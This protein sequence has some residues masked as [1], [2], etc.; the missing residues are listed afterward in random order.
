MKRRFIFVICLVL[1][2][3]CACDQQSQAT[4]KIYSE[5][6]LYKMYTEDGKWY[7]EF[8]QP[9][10]GKVGDA[11]STNL[12]AITYPEFD[13]ATE[14]ADMLKSGIIRDD[15][16]RYLKRISKKNVVE[17]LN[18]NKICELKTPNS[19][20]CANVDWTSDVIYKFSIRG[21]EANGYVRCYDFDR[22]QYTKKFE[23]YRNFP[24][25][26]HTVTSDITVEDRNARTVY[27]YTS[28]CEMKN[29]LYKITAGESDI[30]VREIYILRYFDEEATSDTFTVSDTVPDSIEIWGSDGTHCWYGSFRDFE[31][32]PSVEWLSSFR[33][34]PIE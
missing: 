34:T 20:T 28:A 15:C 23:E 8:L 17:I 13:S 25:E 30:Y 14:F 10:D 4:Q 2:L 26:N 6:E 22:E 3:L 24:N 5:S 21:E 12:T 19:L 16:V 18:P 1:S 27:S 11:P 32:R 29:I 33:L 31:E 7:I 9:A